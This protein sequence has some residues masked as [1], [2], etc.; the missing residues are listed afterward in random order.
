MTTSRRSCGSC[1]LPCDPR[2]NA[3]PHGDDDRA[4][5]RS[6]AA[7]QGTPGARDRR[8][9]RAHYDI[10]NDFFASM[11]DPTMT[12]SCGLFERPQMSLVDAQRAKLDR[13][14]R[15]LELTPEDELLEIGSGWGSFAI[16]AASCY[17]CR[18]T[19]TT[20]SDAQFEVARERVA[21]AGLTHL[22]TVRPDH[23]RDA[24]RAILEA[25]F[26][27]DVRGGRLA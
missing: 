1:S 22:V 24:H 14:C 15:L 26:D 17:G 6:G 5:R 7:A 13:I 19:T 8:N 16:H 12:Y 2:P 3:R 21:S 23:Y 27:R 10:S 20:I 9:I 4:V 18:V 11:L 25:C